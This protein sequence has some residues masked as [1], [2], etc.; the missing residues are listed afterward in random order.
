MQLQTSDA[1]RLQSCARTAALEYMRV[2]EM[3]YLFL[4]SWN[5]SKSCQHRYYLSLDV[6][7]LENI[8]TSSLA[9]N[10]LCK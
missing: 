10:L 2:E 5:L 1:K 7:G 8:Y 3:L 4:I 9:N 6:L